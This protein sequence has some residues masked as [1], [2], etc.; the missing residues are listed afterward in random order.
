MANCLSYVNKTESRTQVHR[1]LHAY[2]ASDGGDLPAAELAASRRLF[3]T[4]AVEGLSAA[5][6]ISRYGSAPTKPKFSKPHLCT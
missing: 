6:R 3:E 1:Y 4:A 2:A 5:E